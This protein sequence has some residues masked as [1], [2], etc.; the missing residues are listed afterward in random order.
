MPFSFRLVGVPWQA[1]A[2]RDVIDTIEAVMPP[3]AWPT[4]V[5]GNH[6]EPRVAIPPDLGVVAW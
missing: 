3:G 2:V 4:W 6:D 1:A 5:L